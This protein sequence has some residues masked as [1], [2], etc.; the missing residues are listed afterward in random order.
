MRIPVVPRM[1]RRNK[2]VAHPVAVL[3]LYRLTQPFG[4]VV[5]LEG[6]I[7]R[8]CEA[9]DALRLYPPATTRL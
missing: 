7:P 8:T 3:C 6:K 4:C 5:R 9:S 2:T 1:H